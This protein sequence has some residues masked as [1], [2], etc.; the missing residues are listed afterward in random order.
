MI[1]TDGNVSHENIER[2]RAEENIRF[3]IANEQV[4]AHEIP[5]YIVGH[6]YYVKN[7]EATIT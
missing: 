2:L 1:I 6:D 5:Q 4:Y 3:A 7:K